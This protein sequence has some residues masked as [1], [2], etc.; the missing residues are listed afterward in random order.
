MGRCICHFIFLSGSR[1]GEVA[2]FESARLT[3][4][5][6]PS[7]DIRFDPHIDLS[8]ASMHAEILYD[9][10]RFLLYDLGSR[11]GT[12][13][14]GKPIGEAYPLRNEDY[15]QFG[16]NG[17]EV[18]FRLGP[19]P[20]NLVMPPPPAIVAELHFRTGSLAG[21]TFQVRS[22]EPVKIGRLP[23]MDIALP[24]SQDIQVSGHHCTIRYTGD[25]FVVQDHSRNGTFVNE[26]LVRG[27][28]P[29]NDGDILRLAPDGPTARF[30]II[31]KKRNYP[32]LRREQ[33]QRTA[34]ARPTDLTEQK[35]EEA[36][37]S[38]QPQT[39]TLTDKFQNQF[40]EL[41]S[42]DGVGEFQQPTDTSPSPSAPQR[43]ARPVARRDRVHRRVLI[44]LATLATVG[45]FA[46]LV[47]VRFPLWLT[48]KAL[49][50]SSSASLAI[51][52]NYSDQIDKGSPLEV[53]EGGYSVVIPR[54]WAKLHR[55]AMVSIESPDK[56]LAVDYVVDPRLNEDAVVE[57]LRAKGSVPKKVGESTVSSEDVISYIGKGGT[58]T[59]LA[60]LR[61]SG[62]TPMLALFD[63]SSQHFAFIPNTVYAKLAFNNFKK[64]TSLSNNL[65]TRYADTTSTAAAMRLATQPQP[66]VPSLTPRVEATTASQVTSAT[67]ETVPQAETEKITSCARSR[68]GLALPPGWEGRANENDGVLLIKTAK[69]LEIRVTRDKNPLVA[70]AIF[71]QMEQDGWEPLE[72]DEKGKTFVGTTLRGYTAFMR[73]H[74]NHACLGLIDQLDSSTLVI[75]TEIPKPFSMEEK[76]EIWGAMERLARFSSQSP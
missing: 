18:V 59:W 40:L 67:P 22:D 11:T 47:K 34:A 1:A 63:V 51:T 46:I 71:R 38:L 9:S 54:G 73:Q 5:R 26:E 70:G 35:Q 60:I 53:E 49:K 23:T 65:A 42:K 36:H 2:E 76:D 30:R 24:P 31:G 66:A 44:A 17:P 3:I 15:I 12:F 37:P 7:A 55:G 57:I 8:V 14:N 68:V 28:A 6:A 64:L 10:G 29:L 43:K 56:I 75:Y 62:N 61:K 21:K 32:N 39:I 33:T 41:S 20:E 58:R 13:V 52:E 48:D 27:E 69:G 19:K 4:G 74:T 50:L 72:T 25:R 45:V 16:E